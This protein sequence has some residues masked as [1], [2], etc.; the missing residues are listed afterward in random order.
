MGRKPVVGC[1]WW[2]LDASLHTSQ[3]F[4]GS[5]RNQIRPLKSTRRLHK[6]LSVSQ[7]NAWAS[8]L[9]RAIGS[10]L[11][12]LRFFRKNYIK[13]SYGDIGGKFFFQ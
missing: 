8:R 3:K 6:R 12:F 7:W 11:E 2:E 4:E 13:P 1:S 9:R 5:A 10:L